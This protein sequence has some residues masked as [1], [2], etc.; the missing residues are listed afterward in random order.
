MPMGK[1]ILIALGP[2]GDATHVRPKN[3][4]SVYTLKNLMK[5]V[6]A[7]KTWNKNKDKYLE[8]LYEPTFDSEY[9]CGCG[10]FQLGEIT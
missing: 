8:D 1:P 5:R 4:R 3:G 10:L 2:M 7:D 6:K 9:G